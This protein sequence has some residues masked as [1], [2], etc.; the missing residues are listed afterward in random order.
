MSLRAFRCAIC[1]QSK[2][3]GQPSIIEKA[4]PEVWGLF[5]GV[6]HMIYRHAINVNVGIC[7]KNACGYKSEYSYGYKSEYS[8]GY[9]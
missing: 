9:N 4:Y 8:Y 7:L 3:I 5:Q 6:Y 1:R 2:Q